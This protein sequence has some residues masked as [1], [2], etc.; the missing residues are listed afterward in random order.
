MTVLSALFATLAFATTGFD[1]TTPEA[2][3]SGVETWT[4]DGEIKLWST[5]QRWDDPDRSLFHPEAYNSATAWPTD[6]S[7][8][9]FI[10][11]CFE[12]T[13]PYSSS[14][15]LHL[16]LNESVAQG[17]PILFVPGAGDNASRGFITLAT[18][19]DNL[20]RPVYAMTFAHP[21]GDVFLQAEAVA[22]AIAVIKAR[23]G[24]EQ[25]DLVGHSKGGIAAVVYTSHTANADWGDADYESIG[26]PYRG[27]VRRLLLIATPL[28]GIDTTYRWSAL[29]YASLE[30]DA[31]LSPSS[32]KT[33]YPSTTAVWALNDSL[34]DQDYA[35]DGADLFPGQRQLVARQDYPLPG[36][37]LW[38]GG[39]ALQPDW[40][41]TYEG[42]L[43]LWSNSDGIDAAVADGGYLIGRLAERGVDPDV[44]IWLLAGA[45]P[46]MP[47]GDAL[48][49]DLFAGIGPNLWSDL[50]DDIDA[51][52][53]PL[54]VDADE[55]DGLSKGKLV[56]GEITGPSDGLV[57][58]S[59]ALYGRSVTARGAVIVEKKKVNLSHLDL[60]YASPITGDLLIE[61]GEANPSEDLWMRGLGRR[62]TEADSLN[63]IAG[64]LS[65]DAVFDDLDDLDDSGDTGVGAPGFADADITDWQRP[66]GGC[67]TGR[68]APLGAVLLVLGLLYRRRE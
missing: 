18:K 58:I 8:A 21:H 65:D 32:W 62:Y 7:F 27:D 4:L 17:T 50:V 40:W 25:V 34:A 31:A 39:Y 13:E 57:F 52:D 44:P 29:N 9:P 47:N 11:V 5:I 41:T 2:E 38:L 1:P 54:A 67:S 15:L 22:D 20:V 12:S 46:L 53:V 37:Q 36:S 51:H 14:F 64:V 49:E 6:S 35:P 24:A 16:G 26:T 28:G 42:G 10:D 33:Y 56:L 43:G 63:W 19:M 3:F 60:L 30:A 45:N 66:C 48:L 55:L 61:A 23:T 59:S 68:E